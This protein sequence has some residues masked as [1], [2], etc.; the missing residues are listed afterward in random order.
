MPNVNMKQAL[1]YPYQF[2]I[3]PLIHVAQPDPVRRPYGGADTN[4]VNGPPGIKCRFS[5]A[6]NADER[7]DPE[8]RIIDGIGIIDGFHQLSIEVQRLGV[9]TAAHRKSHMMPPGFGVI[10][11]RGY[12]YKGVGMKIC[13]D[14]G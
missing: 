13:A 1:F 6:M 5:V 11:A 14:A 4:L 3:L 2:A 10:A 8:V 12:G 7:I 9:T